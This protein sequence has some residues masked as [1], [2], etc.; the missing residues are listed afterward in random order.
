MKELKEY[1]LF[2]MADAMQEASYEAGDL[3]CRQ[4]D[5]GSIFYI[6]KQ[7]AVTCT[8]ADA[9][10]K[11]HEVA[12]LTAGDYFGEI[13]LLTSRPRQASV[14]AAEKSG[15]LKLLHLDR[16]TFNRILGSAEDILRRDMMAY[17]KFRGA[18]I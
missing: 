8:Q 17:N 1:E 11:Q 10:G 13:A 5:L 9:K 3:V 12:R 14:I 7:G 6:I 15:T 16:R 18:Q 4:G 2:T